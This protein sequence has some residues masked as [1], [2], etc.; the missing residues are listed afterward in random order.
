MCWSGGKPD[1]DH[2]TP[3]S[4]FMGQRCL[5][6]H[7]IA[8]EAGATDSDYLQHLERTWMSFLYSLD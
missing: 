8:T 7:I 4:P 1:F 6:L 5:M 3:T 2:F